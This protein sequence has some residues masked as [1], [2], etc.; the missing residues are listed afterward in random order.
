MNVAERNKPLKYCH[1][2]FKATFDLSKNCI[3]AL[4][5]CAYLI[6]RR[7]K[8]QKVENILLDALS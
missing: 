1:S 7:F 5:R 2:A 4:M 8:V 6:F 3:S